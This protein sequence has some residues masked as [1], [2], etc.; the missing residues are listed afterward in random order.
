VQ[1]DTKLKSLKYQKKRA[2]E[3]K[4][5]D[6]EIESILK[7]EAKAL[8]KA[9]AKVTRAEKYCDSAL[10]KAKIELLSGEIACL[11]VINAKLKLDE[12]INQ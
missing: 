11:E 4:V 2:I 12:V 1:S 3:E 9:I 8:D 5:Q 7:R 10:T 6:L